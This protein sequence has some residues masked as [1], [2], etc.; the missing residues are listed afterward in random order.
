MV[1]LNMVSLLLHSEGVRMC[2]M[3][4]ARNGRLTDFHGLPQRPS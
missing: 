3:T 2:F 4:T 1:S